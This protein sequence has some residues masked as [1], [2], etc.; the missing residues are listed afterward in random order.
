MEAGAEAD[1]RGHAERDPPERAHTAPL[2]LRDRRVLRERERRQVPNEHQRRQREAHC[3]LP[4]ER[5][6]RHT[7]STMFT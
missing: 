5:S 7:E 3:Q 1:R 4:L 6:A 2:R